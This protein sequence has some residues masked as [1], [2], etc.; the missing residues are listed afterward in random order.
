MELEKR[1]RV[2]AIAASK[3]VGTLQAMQVEMSKGMEAIEGRFDEKFA[4]LDA[5]CTKLTALLSKLS[6]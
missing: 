3:I 4:K 2:R 6:S 1:E 5:R